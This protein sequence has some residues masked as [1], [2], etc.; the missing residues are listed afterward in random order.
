MSKL[1]FLVAIG[2]SLT[3]R[4]AVQLKEIEYKAGDQTMLG[5]LAWDDL[6]QDKRPG[7]L[8]IHEWWGNNDYAKMRARKLAELGYVAFAADMFGK[9]KTTSDPKQA[10]EWSGWVK[11]HSDQAV[12]RLE[13][14]L[15]VL[16]EQPQVNANKIGA[17]GYCFGGTMALDA[18]A[19]NL[20]DIK[21]VVTFHGGLD[22]ISKPKAPVKAKILVCTGT[23][24]QMIPPKQVEKFEKDFKSAGADVRV[25][26][27]PG[28]H[29]SFTNPKADEYHIPNISYNK[30]A[31]EKSWEDMKQFFA[32]LF[33]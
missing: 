20:D 28:A 9:G 13:A 31:D 16:R 14:A 5:Y 12:Q 25:I 7:I 18:A 11:Q 32:E 29:H 26:S 19:R 23:D 17:I 10:G 15:N 30:E 2:L 3:A 4:A 21:G 6:S 33:K 24:D 1:M 8:V 27:Y 22:G